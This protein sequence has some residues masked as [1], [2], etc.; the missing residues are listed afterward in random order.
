MGGDN[1]NTI[2]KQINYLKNKI[3][4]TKNGQRWGT[5]EGVIKMLLV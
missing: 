3:E 2:K 4:A 1:Q 5:Q